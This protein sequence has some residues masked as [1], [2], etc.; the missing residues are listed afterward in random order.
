MIILGLIMQEQKEHCS[1]L[2]PNSILPEVSRWYDKSHTSEIVSEMKTILP[3]KKLAISKDCSAEIS[4]F[5]LKAKFIK[6]T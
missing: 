3:Q 4:A 5:Q 6:T 1:H 2:L